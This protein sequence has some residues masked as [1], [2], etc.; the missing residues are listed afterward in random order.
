MNGPSDFFL[1]GKKRPAKKKK[2]LSPLRLKGRGSR[3]DFVSDS[4]RP[5]FFSPYGYTW[6]QKKSP[7]FF[8]KWLGMVLSKHFFQKKKDVEVFH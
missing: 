2:K 6:N 3:G 1:G 5:I 8:F 4:S 7:A